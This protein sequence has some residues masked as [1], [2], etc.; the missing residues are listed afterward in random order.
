[1]PAGCRRDSREEIALEP[2]RESSDPFGAALEDKTRGDRLAESEIAAPPADQRP[3]I[4]THTEFLRKSRVEG[5]QGHLGASEQEIVPARS[6]HVSE[7]DPDDDRLLGE[8]V[9]TNPAMDVPEE[10]AWVQLA[11]LRLTR[12]PPLAPRT[13]VAHDGR[14][15]E[16]G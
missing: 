4:R 14:E 12:E 6:A 7:L 2:A 15:L 1:M 8:R 3:A 11:H 5:A 9:P 10:R 16:T 13:E